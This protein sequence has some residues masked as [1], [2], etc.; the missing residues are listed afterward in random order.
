MPSL[1]SVLHPPKLVA[2]L[3]Q[4]PG[5]RTGFKQQ[6]SLW[7]LTRVEKVQQTLNELSNLG[8]NT[9]FCMYLW[10]SCLHLAPLCDSCSMGFFWTL[11]SEIFQL[12][13]AISANKP[14]RAALMQ[15]LLRTNGRPSL[16][17]QSEKLWKVPVDS[18][19]SPVRE[20]SIC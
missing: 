4:L 2:I 20:K 15:F 17:V 14:E 1:N 8:A 3:S 11:Y 7:L 12:G 16:G 10:S 5:L 6:L 13:M 19:L 9:D 18:R